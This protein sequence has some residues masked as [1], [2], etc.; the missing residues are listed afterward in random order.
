MT[1]G[2]LYRLLFQYARDEQSSPENDSR[3]II[4]KPFDA[5]P[6]VIYLILFRLFTFVGLL[7]ALLVGVLAALLVRHFDG[8]LTITLLEKKTWECGTI[9]LQV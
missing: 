6:K 7:M 4:I 3:S 1:R 5:V 9:M 8:N 2:K